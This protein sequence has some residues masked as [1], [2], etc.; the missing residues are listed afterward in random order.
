MTGGGLRL[1]SKDLLKLGQL[2]LNGGTWNGKRIIPEQWVKTST[3][4]HAK[5]DDQTEYGYLWWLKK[6]KAG[7]KEYPCYYMSGNG[8][9]KIA[10]FPELQSVV[11]ITSTNYATAGMHQLTDKLLTEYIL[12]L[13]H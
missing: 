8:G 2:Y 5:I 13:I 11:V 6:F 10:V 12:P 7:D 3:Q 4:P 9:N 1:Q